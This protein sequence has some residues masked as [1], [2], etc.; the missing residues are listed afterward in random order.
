MAVFG[1]IWSHYLIP[2]KQI[3]IFFYFTVIN[4][5]VYPLVV[6]NMYL[7]NRLIKKCIFTFVNF[8]VHPLLVTLCA[9]VQYF[10]VIIIL[11]NCNAVLFVPK[12]PHRPANMNNSFFQALA[13]R[14]PRS[15]E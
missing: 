9:L 14:I 3:Y 8:S 10:V 5:S 2:F 4:C 15:P 12:L 6:I 13:R 11:V 7:S 1:E